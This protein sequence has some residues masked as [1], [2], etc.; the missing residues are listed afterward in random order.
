MAGRES[1]EDFG[2]KRLRAGRG[3]RKYTEEKKGKEKSKDEVSWERKEEEIVS[4][5]GRRNE[6]ARTER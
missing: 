3:M 1:G 2:G 5:E 4:N 6:S